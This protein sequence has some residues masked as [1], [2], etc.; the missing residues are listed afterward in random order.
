MSN[1]LNSELVLALNKHW[2]V[3]GTKTVRRAVEDL[4]SGLNGRKP[5]LAMDIDLD[6]NGGLIS[7]SPVDWETW[8]TLPVRPYDIPIQCAHG[9]V[10]RCPTVIISPNYGDNK[11]RPVRLTKEAIK[12]RDR[13]ECQYCHQQ[14]PLDELNI[15]H[16]L[17][18]HHGGKNTWENMVCSCIKCNR[19][20][21]HQLNEQIG[22]ELKSQPQEP[23]AVPNGFRYSRAKHETWLPFL[24]RNDK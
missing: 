1:L 3:I 17:P 5:F 9:R 2:L 13:Y 15:D 7:A 24:V 6:D 14:F 10:I 11:F 12:Q 4:C 19:D 21:G 16:V 23:K 22:Y 18:R 20:K 8:Q